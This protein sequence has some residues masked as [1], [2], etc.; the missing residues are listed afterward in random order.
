MLLVAAPNGTVRAVH[1][2]SRARVGALVL[3][4]ED[5]LAVVGHARRAF[6]RG[7]FVRRAHGFDFLAAGGRMLA[8]KGAAPASVQ[9][10]DVITSKVEVENENELAEDEVNEIGEIGQVRVVGVVAS[11]AA[12][13]VTLT[14]NGQTLTIPLPAGVTVPATAVGTQ[15][16][17]NVSFAGAAQAQPANDDDDNDQGG[18]DDHG[19]HHGDDGGH[20][21]HGGG[22]DDGGGDG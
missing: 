13:S 15:V 17:V 16:Q 19:D 4:S 11:V 18:D 10:G 12:G 8:L 20:G 6:V 21:D 22:G 9:P 3:L 1:T 5:R 14:V 2:S 7:V